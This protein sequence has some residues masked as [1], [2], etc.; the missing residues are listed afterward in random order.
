MKGVVSNLNPWLVPLF[1]CIHS[2]L[3]F[4]PRLTSR[5]S[6][7]VIK[8]GLFISVIIKSTYNLLV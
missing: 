2:S 6:E 1:F 8:V 3:K 4:E 7:Y 5:I